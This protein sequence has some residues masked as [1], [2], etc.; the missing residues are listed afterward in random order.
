M[1]GVL[2][3][4]PSPNMAFLTPSSTVFAM[5]VSWFAT[6]GVLGYSGPDTHRNVSSEF[7]EDIRVSFPCETVLLPV[8]TPLEVFS[9]HAVR[10][11][12][13]Y[14]ELRMLLSRHPIDGS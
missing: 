3:T 12:R 4:E 9:C 5:N 6:G 13:I 10:V 7:V 8:F 11:A 14:R 2:W 1:E